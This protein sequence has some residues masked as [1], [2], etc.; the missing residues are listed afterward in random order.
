MHV[1]HA[2]PFDTK[3]M[4]GIGHL[5]R[6]AFAYHIPQTNLCRTECGERGLA[7]QV[8]PDDEA[9]AFLPY[10]I[11]GWPFAEPFRIRYIVILV[12]EAMIGGDDHIG[13]VRVG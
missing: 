12:E 4:D 6:H 2:R 10:R 13:D 1:S 3:A 11:A 9:S 5:N 8:G 7:D